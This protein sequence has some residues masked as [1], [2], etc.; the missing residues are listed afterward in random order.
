MSVG[1][2][3]ILNK[4]NLSSKFFKRSGRSSIFMLKSPVRNVVTFWSKID[5]NKSKSICKVSAVALGG[6]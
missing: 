4:F 2:V 1:S 3:I 5:D 6:R